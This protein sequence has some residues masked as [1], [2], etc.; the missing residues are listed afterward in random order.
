MNGKYRQ[1]PNHSKKL[2]PVIR[3][4]PGNFTYDDCPITRKDSY[5]YRL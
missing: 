1:S 3:L 5:N 4:N 2:G